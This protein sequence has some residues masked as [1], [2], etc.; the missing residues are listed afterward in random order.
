MKNPF[1][2]NEILTKKILERLTDEFSQ[3]YKEELLL[4][5]SV[6]FQKNRRGNTSQQC[7]RPVLFT[8]KLN[9]VQE[10]RNIQSLITIEAKIILQFNKINFI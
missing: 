9:N 2:V 4:I 10:K 3:T 6:H 7:S 5:H 1:S 8:S